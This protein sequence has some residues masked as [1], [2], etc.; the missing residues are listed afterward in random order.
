MRQ[1]FS[2]KSKRLLPALVLTALIASAGRA[3]D[4]EAEARRL[5]PPEASG[6]EDPT[7]RNLASRMKATLDSVPHAASRA[8]ADRTRAE[9]RHNLER[10]LGHK[11]LPWPPDLKSRVVSTLR[12]DGYRVEN[13]VYQGLPGEWI[14]AQLYIPTRREGRA[15]AV[16]F[17]NGHWFPDSKSRPDFQAFCINMAKFGFIVLNFETI[18]QGERGLSSR[19]HRRTEGLL[20]GV[21]QQG[22]AVYDTQVAL[23]YLLTRPEVDPK[24]IGMT[25]ASG[26]GFNTWMNAALDDRISVAVPVV[27]TCNFHEQAMV[28]IP[29]DWDPSDHCHYVPGLF[30]YANNHELLTMSAP[31]PVLIVAAAQ[32]ASFP[33]AGVHEVVDHG[34]H[35]YKSYGIPQQFGYFEDNAEGHGY[36]I[37]KRQA[38]YGWFRRWLMQQGDGSPVPEPPTV[39]LAFDAPE[40]RSFS[41]GENKSSGPSL[42]GAAQKVAG[43]LPRSPAKIDLVGALGPWPPAVPWT[44]QIG[45]ERM[46]R[47]TVPTESDLQAPAILLRPKRKMQGLLL[48]VDDRGKEAVFADPVVEQSLKE[49]WAVLAVDPRGIGELASPRKTWIFA[50]SLM[51]GENFVWRQ[52]WDLLRSLQVVNAAPEIGAPRV[53][54]YA[55]GPNAALACSYLIGYNRHSKRIPLSWFLLRDGFVSFRDFLDRPESLP[56]SYEL[57]SSNQDRSAPLDREIPPIFFPFDALRYFDLPGLLASAR[58]PGLI[59]NPLD[60][61]WRPKSAETAGRLFAGDIGVISQDAPNSAIAR[62]VQLHEK[63]PSRR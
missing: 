37:R 6:S 30:R 60:G 63:Q 39:T 7:V 38:A 23:E 26:G 31:K 45:P 19:D 36:Q 16:L 20:A 32:D 47:L 52:A 51:Q 22:Y 62:F 3:A 41:P 28:R 12:G 54:I 9:L 13:V 1:Q 15:P 2:T 5:R 25:G 29:R 18:G 59:V 40:L 61:D 48:A 46:Q 44:P 53:A 33:I 21:S 17:Y 8:E 35:L 10:S 42:V 56:R 4:W 14:P 27:G 58:I 11:R 50:I 34:R 57:R 49:D 43:A 55:R 24:R